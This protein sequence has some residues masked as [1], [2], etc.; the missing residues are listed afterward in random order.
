MWGGG[1]RLAANTAANAGSNG[2]C[3]CLFVPTTKSLARPIL[4]KHAPPPPT[5]YLTPASTIELSADPALAR[6]CSSNTDFPS[7]PSC[8]VRTRQRKSK[9]ESKEKGKACRDVVS[10]GRRRAGATPGPPGPFARLP[11][12]SRTLLNQHAVLSLP[13]T[14]LSKTTVHFL[15]IE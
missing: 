15:F 10:S 9:K 13:R 11:A 12:E 7:E 5:P 14:D 2:G 8:L 6:I 4:W 1:G 3:V